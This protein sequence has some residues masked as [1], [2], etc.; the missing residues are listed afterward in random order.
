MSLSNPAAN[1]QSVFESAL[2]NY[3]KTTKND[4]ASHPLLTKLESCHSPE[5]IL[6]TLRGQI[7]WSDLAQSSNDKVN[8]VAWFDCESTL[9]LFLNH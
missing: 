3:R 2:E 4:L 9:C 7:L 6:T 5:A 1:Y 8:N